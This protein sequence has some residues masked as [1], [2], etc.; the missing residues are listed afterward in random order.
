MLSD[1]Y[2]EKAINKLLNNNNKLQLDIFTDDV[3]IN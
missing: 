2:Y 1:T 3:N